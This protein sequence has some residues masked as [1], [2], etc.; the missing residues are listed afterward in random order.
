MICGANMATKHKPK[1]T[2]AKRRNVV[3]VVLRDPSDNPDDAT[4]RTLTRP[5]IQAAATIKMWEGDIH[6]VNALSRELTAQVA[7]VNGGDLKR[8]EGMLIAQ[9][10]TLDAL[11]NNLARLAH[12]GLRLLAGRESVQREVMVWIRLKSLK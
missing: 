10:H 6:E 4:A 1:A 9:A 3:K 11:F 5:E 12:L 7:A 2:P 8:A